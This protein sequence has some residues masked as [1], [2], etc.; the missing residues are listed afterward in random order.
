[1]SADIYSFTANS[2]KVNRAISGADTVSANSY[3]VVFYTVTTVGAVEANS[4]ISTPPVTRYFGPAQTI[5]ATF[6]NVAGRG[7]NGGAESN[8]T[9]TYTLQS[10][11]EFINT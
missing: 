9:S 2:L 5:P 1:M 4:S 3:A 10:G 6:T 8:T 11:V 7:D